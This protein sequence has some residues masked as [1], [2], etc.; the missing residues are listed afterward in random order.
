MRALILTTAIL[1]GVLTSGYS[2]TDKRQKRTAEE[3]AKL[4]TEMLEKKLSL[5][6]DQKAKVYNLQLDQAKKMEKMRADRSEE[7][8]DRMEKHKEVMADN[9]KKLEK[10][11]D[12]DQLKSYRESKTNKRERA[13]KHRHGK[14]GEKMH[15]E[16]V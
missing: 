11:L 1:F 13:T 8:K 9:D 12:A 3:R 6:A 2:Q 4:K 5:T 15:K 14:K 10:I 7:M 16:K